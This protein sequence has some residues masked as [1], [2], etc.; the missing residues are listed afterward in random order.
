MRALPFQKPRLQRLLSPQLLAMRVQQSM[1]HLGTR[2]LH[3]MQMAILSPQARPV[4]TVRL[5][6]A[7]N[8]AGISWRGVFL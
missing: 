4:H 5:Q 1:Q 2:P 6:L 7:L 8:E 3:H